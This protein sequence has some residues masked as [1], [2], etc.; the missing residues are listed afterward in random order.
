MDSW[1]TVDVDLDGTGDEEYEW[2]DDVMKDLESRFYELRQYNKKFN[3][4]RYKDVREETPI[5]ID[6]TRRDIEELVANEIYDK[7]TILLNNTFK[8]KI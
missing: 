7:L 4:S 6:S 2:N 1:E 5:F 3:D 8:K